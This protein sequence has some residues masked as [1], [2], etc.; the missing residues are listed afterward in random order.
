MDILEK[1][2]TLL[3]VHKTQDEDK[4]RKNTTRYLLLIVLF[5]LECLQEADRK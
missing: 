3:R 1:L 2:T 4:Q 5:L